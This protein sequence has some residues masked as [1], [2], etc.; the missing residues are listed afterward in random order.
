MKVK[1]KEESKGLA[2]WDNAPKEAM[3][4][5]VDSDG[6]GWFYDSKPITSISRWLTYGNCITIV[7]STQHEVEDWTKT[8][9]K[10]P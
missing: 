5:A 3:Y 2:D 10:R 6:R 7:G 8:L 1:T 4:F 9:E